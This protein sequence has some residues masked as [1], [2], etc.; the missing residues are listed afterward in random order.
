MTSLKIQVGHMTVTVVVVTGTIPP[1]S[2]RLYVSIYAA[3]QSD[4]EG[5]PG[6]VR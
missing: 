5:K 6:R 2:P 3:S 1:P 4:P